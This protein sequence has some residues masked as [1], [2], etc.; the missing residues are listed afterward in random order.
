MAP[1]TNYNSDDSIIEEYR[2]RSVH[3]WWSETPY[4]ESIRRLSAKRAWVTNT[5]LDE[6]FAQNARDHERVR[7]LITVG[8]LTCFVATIGFTLVASMTPAWPNAKESLLIVLPAVSGFFGSAITYYYLT[9]L[10]G[11]RR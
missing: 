6:T 5:A 11:S 1:A 8:L 9:V 2:A 3:F 10:T 7:E 4:A